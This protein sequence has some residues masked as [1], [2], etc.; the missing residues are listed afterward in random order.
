[1][2]WEGGCRE[3]TDVVR[4]LRVASG[5]D[6][7]PGWARSVCAPARRLAAARP[8]RIMKYSVRLAIAFFILSTLP[9]AFVSYISTVSA[10]RTVIRELENHLVTIA[11]MRA[12]DFTRWVKSCEQMAES[13]AQRPLVV[14]LV[15]DLVAQAHEMVPP[16][17]AV[18][19]LLLDSHLRPHLRT[20]VL[21]EV[22]SIADAETGRVLVSTDPEEVGSTRAEEVY[23]VEGRFGTHTGSVRLG[24]GESRAL[25]VGT[26][27]GIDGEPP[28]AILVGRVQR[29]GIEQIIRPIEDVHRTGDVYLVDRD[30]V[31]FTGLR[32]GENV[33]LGHPVSTEG[34][35]RALDGESGVARYVDYREVPVLGAFR[36]LPE[37]E[38]AIVAEI[39]QQEA[40]A[41]LDDA[42]GIGLVLLTASIVIFTGLGFT[43]A[44]WM[45]HPLRRISAGAAKIGRG[46]FGHRIRST[47]SD[48]LGDL[49]RTFDR[50]AENLQQITAS[51]DDLRRE[52]GLRREAEEELQRALGGLQESEGMFRL[53]SEASPVG[54]FIVQG[55][56]FKYVNPA[57]ERMLGYASAEL[58]DGPSPLD[59]TDPR[60][61]P[62]VLAHMQATIDRSEGMPPLEF[63]ALAKDGTR[64]SCEVR[65]RAIEYGGETALVG[66][67]ADVTLRRRAEE[68]FRLAAGVASDLIYEWEIETDR[69]EWFGDIDA[70]LGYEDGATPRTIDGWIGLIHPDDQKRLAG[71]VERHRTGTEPIYE[72]YRVR[73]K[74]GSW[75]HWIDRAVPILLGGDRPKRW[76]G[77]CIDETERLETHRALS[78]AEERFRRI[79][80]NAPDVICRYRL[81]PNPGFEYLSPAFAVVTG[82]DP[83]AVYAD[84]TLAVR[85]V[86]PD[87]RPLVERLLRGELGAGVLDVRWIHRDGHIVWM[88]S[89]QTP[90]RDDQGNLVAVEIIARD[91]TE[92]TEARRALAESEEKYRLLFEG[93]GIGIG[94]YSPDGVLIEFNAI[95]AAHMG[96]APEDFTGKTVLELFGESG[97]EYLQRIVDVARTSGLQRFEDA[98]ELPTGSKWFLSTYSRVEDA[99]G[100]VVGVQVLS[101]EITDRKAAEK[102]LRTADEIVSAIPTGILIYRYQEPD[103][104]ILVSGNVAAAPFVDLDENIGQGVEN[105]WPRPMVERLKA[106]LLTIAREGGVYDNEASVGDAEA[107]SAF[108]L[109]AFRIPGDR[110]VVAFEDIT[111][112]KRAETAVAA[113]KNRY[114]SA[115]EASRH[116]LYDWD[117]RT[118]D[119]TYGGDL[120]RILGYGS[121]EMG[122]GLSHWIE[123]VH[124]DDR[125]GFEEEIRGLIGT[126]EP[127]HLQYRVR[128]KDGEYIH[129]EDD[130]NFITDAEGRPIRMLGFVKDVTE[131]RRAEA[132]VE[133]SERRYRAIVE[134]A[135]AGILTVDLKGIVSSCNRAFTEMTGYPRDELVGRHFTKLP[136]VR[137]QDLPKYVRLLA[138]I[139]RGRT[140]APF[141]TIWTKP[142]GRARY[143]E[144]RVALLRREE[145]RWGVQVIV[146]DITDR[147]VAET[148]LRESEAKYRALVEEIREVIYTT[149][150]AGI[151]TYVSP[152]VKQLGN[153]TP[154][155]LIG[156]PYES[157][158]FGDDLPGIDEMKQIFERTTELRPTDYRLVAKDGSVRWV[159]TTGRPILSEGRFAGMRGLLVDVTEAKRAE[160]ALRVSEE[161]YRSLFENATLGIYQTTPDG[162]IVAANPAMVR[163]LGYDSFDELASR[164]LEEEG[165]EPEASRERFKARIEREG[166]V[167]GLES[168]WTRKDGKRLHVR[169]NAVAVRDDDGKVLFYE[170]TVEDI[171]AQREA[172]AE[173][174]NLEAQLRQTQKLE[175]I[176]TL[177]SGVAH[178]INNP[179]T[180][181][182]NY[183]ELI[184]RR[185]D[186][187]RLKDFAEAIMSEGARVAT[188][189]R[190]LLSFSRQEKESHSPARVADILAATMTLVGRLLEKDHIRVE[191]DVP[192]N[193]PKVKCRSQQLQQVLLNLLTNARDALNERYPGENPSKLVRVTAR[194]ATIDDERWIRV[195]VEDR[196]KGIPEENLDRVFDPF[197]TTKPR[198]RGTGLGLSISYGIVRDHGGR[199][200]AE[201]EEGSCTRFVLDLPVDNG[202]RLPRHEA[203][204]SDG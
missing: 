39:D 192:E 119:V 138:G 176:G 165:Y 177:A 135:P 184:A 121:S 107:P 34:V 2:T 117:V 69:L 202:W 142:D 58:V 71:S 183:A 201:S 199:L 167:E 46:E 14:D 151:L 197:F 159:R 137:V 187:P 154:D 37:Y 44:R 200:S 91:V 21:F 130:G 19:A 179:L 67:L 49:A 70:A 131:Q 55:M 41:A 72:T 182:I 120:E 75:R 116:I 114:E 103:R 15:G 185:V 172:E 73:C 190:N 162:R 57:M 110:V 94:Y 16:D 79:L 36:W 22:F 108:H 11:E 134:M 5:R 47:R 13:I 101:E 194:A 80:E 181:M 125:E 17:P 62:I 97:P 158:G 74:D 144:V 111:E 149:D 95:A 23:V 65:S 193:L 7:P 189:V 12:A 203:E 123:L 82:Y 164:N 148:E 93:A 145:H 136:P 87:D 161:Q 168:V 40:F 50:M 33:A 29:R 18:A 153:Y 157:L 155:E 166:R 195:V 115:V 122:G 152:S 35:E 76:I 113:W 127:A 170:G 6:R 178:E 139:L 104:L 42:R 124:P 43:L 169:E 89:R 64:I 109:R 129:V 77:V 60:G 96:G 54:V 191:V 78:E 8:R 10:E 99:D 27:I 132:Q 30:A 100:A 61:D 128:R 85:V 198:D 160:E 146:Q 141:E 53:L 88:E 56:R 102:A 98:V 83:K 4:C 59:L 140:P 186:E 92:W 175:S 196:G 143:G 156:R 86:H 20:G 112:R 171:T 133:A 173:R 31:P 90:I 52:I 180:G 25:F 26:P 106:T 188:I 118:G 63:T 3:S 68:R 84:Q 1:L 66:T 163:M 32:F 9:V 126:L 51:R 38:M 147:K 81:G 105:H 24:K 45:T 28:I 204:G 174:R 48:E 150:E